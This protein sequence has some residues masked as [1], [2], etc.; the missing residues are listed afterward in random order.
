MRIS[1]RQGLPVRHAV[2]GEY[3]AVALLTALL[4]VVIKLHYSLAGATALTWVLAP[5]TYL[6]ELFTAQ[7]FLFH[8][9]KGYVAVDLPVVI[10]PGCAGLNFYV[11]TLCTSV[12]AFIDR[13]DRQRLYGWLFLAV[14]AYPV[15]LLVNAFRI[16]GG[17]VLLKVGGIAGLHTDGV[18]HSAQGMLFFF[19]F[20]VGYLLLLQFLIEKRGA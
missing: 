7:P 8:P 4:A 17:M 19:V 16:I 18:M 2:R 14:L 9:D 20:L 3:A 6:V 11:I 1:L 10:G 12:F 15:T 5:T 13:F